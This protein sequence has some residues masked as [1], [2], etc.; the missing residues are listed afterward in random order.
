MS[1]V[2]R[3]GR[4][5]GAPINATGAF[6][7]RAE[8]ETIPLLMNEPPQPLTRHARRAAVALPPG[9]LPRRTPPHQRQWRP[10]R[11]PVQHRGAAAERRGAPPRPCT[12]PETPQPS[13]ASWAMP[14]ATAAALA[15]RAAA[16]PPVPAAAAA[17]AAA[18]AVAVAVAGA[19]GR[20]H[21]PPAHAM[22]VAV[23]AGAPVRHGPVSTAGQKVAAPPSPP[24]RARLAAAAAP[25]SPWAASPGSSAAGR[26]GLGPGRC[27]TT[28]RGRSASARGSPATLPGRR[29]CRCCLRGS[30]GRADDPRVMGR[31]R[32]TLGERTSSSAAAS[33]VC[34]PL[35]RQRAP[36]GSPVDVVRTMPG[37]S[38]VTW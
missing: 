11:L 19:A 33:G 28:A 6:S 29:K 8:R 25:P 2:R 18:A 38:V 27:P 24:G 12:T 16:L 30:G 4:G 3:W 36:S 9:G 22:G 20:C 7:G 10:P 21:R 26:G 13:G 17:A 35:P 32:A 5:R 14:A 1:G 34:S 15:G 37:P 31:G 23:A